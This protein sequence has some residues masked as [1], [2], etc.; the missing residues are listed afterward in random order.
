[1]PNAFYVLI[2]GAPKEHTRASE[3]SLFHPHTEP[4]FLPRRQPA[5]NGSSIAIAPGYLPC[6]ETLV[7]EMRYFRPVHAFRRWHVQLNIS[8]LADPCEKLLIAFRMD[9]FR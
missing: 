1:L 4:K 7:S 3:V 8:V 6:R 5:A 9:I 2:F